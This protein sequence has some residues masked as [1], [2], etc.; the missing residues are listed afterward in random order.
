M[1]AEL[2]ELLQQREEWR[3]PG[4]SALC[5]RVRA[6]PVGQF[7]VVSFEQHHAPS[8]EQYGISIGA[9]QAVAV[10]DVLTGPLAVRLLH[11]QA[12]VDGEPVKLT[13]TEYRILACLAVRAGRVVPGNAILA[14]VWGPEYAVS[15]WYRSELH[16]LRVNVARLRA[17]LGAARRLLVTRPGFGYMLLAEPYMGP[18]L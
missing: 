7:G 13:P 18:S 11:A 5:H 4:C 1:A 10:E 8:H 6:I 17:R 16:L 9:M 3:G 12:L 14:D 2:R 15:H